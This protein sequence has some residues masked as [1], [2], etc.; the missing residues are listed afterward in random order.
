MACRVRSLAES[1]SYKPMRIRKRG[2]IQ[3]RLVELGC[4]DGRM[5]AVIEVS[6]D[7]TVTCQAEPEL[8]GQLKALLFS[9]VRFHGMGEYERLRPGR[10]RVIGLNVDSFEPL[11]D[12]SLSESI[13]RI[14]SRN[15]DNP[16]W[17]G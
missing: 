12:E 1:D 4:R 9:P 14:R 6:R 5:Y 16:R 11:R 8:A 10:W 2:S 15:S 17:G 3:G 13:A 7:E